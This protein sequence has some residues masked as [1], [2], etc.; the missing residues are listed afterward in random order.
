LRFTC[1]VPPDAVNERIALVLKRQLAAIDVDMSVEEA[2]MDRIV[3]AFKNRRFEAAL[4]EGISGPTLLRLYQLWHSK[5]AVNPGGFGSPRI[6]ASLDR[7]RHAAS[8]TEYL[9]AVAGFQQTMVDDPPAIFLAWVQR[10]RA[11][12]KRFAVPPVEQGRDVLSNLRMWKPLTEATRT[13][14]N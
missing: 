14:H 10:A 12:N 3:D 7:I 4:V 11:V 6:D 5:G 1:L 13:S 8:D 2:P 9:S